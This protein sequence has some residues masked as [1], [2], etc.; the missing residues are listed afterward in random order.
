MAAAMY[1]LMIFVWGF[2]WI[3]IKWQQGDVATEV[4]IFYRFA[5]ASLLMF[6]IGLVFK[7]LQT[8]KL[9]QHPWFALQGLCLFCMNFMAFYS[10]THYIASGLTAVIMATAP[11]FN[12]FHGRLFYGTPTTANFWLGVLVGLSG[13]VLLF[14][15]DLRGAMDTSSGADTLLWGLGFSL[16]G[17][18]FFSIG[19]MISMR[20]TRN[21]V[22]PFTATAYAM[23]YGCLALL[24]I[25]A[26]KGL[27]FTLPLTPTYLGGLLYLAIPASVIG[28]TT[29][30]MLVDRIGANGAAY[31]LV[32][33]PIVALAVSSVFEGY[34]W[35]WYSSAG[36][37]LVL[38]GNILTRRQKP[39]R[40]FGL[41]VSKAA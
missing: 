13:I 26:L 38:M 4:S 21:Q 11:I 5:L 37:L 18:W 6:L 3:A 7:K 1:L 31:L 34:Q 9:S 8:T 36:L 30:L 2:S 35:T 25:I 17:T 39:L 24:F 27:S 41:T 28:F 10:A 32:I 20:N 12:A 40:V 33:T 16:L 19:N 15:V 22:S 23:L 29:Y 14:G